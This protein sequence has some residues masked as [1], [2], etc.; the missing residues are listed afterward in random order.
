[1][2]RNRSRPPIADK[3]REQLL[4]SGREG[5][6]ADGETVVC[7]TFCDYMRLCLYDPHY[8]YYR[9]GPARVGREGDFYTSPFVGDAMGRQLASSLRKL[10]DEHFG[11]GIVNVV[12]WG[13]GTGRLVRQLAEAWSDEAGGG[14][15]RLFVAEDHPAHR[16]EAE[17]TLCGDR[18]R[19][20]ATVMDSAQAESYPWKEHNAI[21]IANELLDAFPV[22]RV[23]VREGELLEWGVAW[24]ESSAKPEACLTR[25]SRPELAAR[26]AADGI[27]LRDGQ[28]VEIGLEAVEW[29]AGMAGKLGDALLAVID[30]GDEA[31]ELAAP[32]RTDGTLV[33]YRRHAAGVDPY[34]APGEQDMTAHVNFTAVRA[35]AAAAG[36]RPVWQGT[37]QRFL[38][39]SGILE[40]L[41]AHA[42]TD[43]F[44]PVVRRNRS[45]RQLLLSDAMS[46]LFKVHIFFKGNGSRV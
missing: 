1:M 41:S 17:R 42:I 7:L 36:W 45:I 43:P 12:D 37:Q 19:P 3:F 35:A 2:K 10:A 26:L 33:C 32:H 30:Y 22:H 15:F 20:M 46:E 28:T 27:G 14:R 38:I 39:E 44:D 13:G 23:T 6:T 5:R 25:P 29:I 8:G 16:R 31:G 21:V 11:A 34:E 40:R 9:S 4:R 24:A 18:A